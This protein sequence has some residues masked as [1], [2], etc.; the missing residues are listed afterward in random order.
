MSIQYPIAGEKIWA[1]SY[2]QSQRMSVL[3][4]AYNNIYPIAQT[5]PGD[6]SYGSSLIGYYTSGDSNQQVFAPT[7]Y[8][9]DFD[10][11]DDHRFL[12]ICQE[13]RNVQRV[14]TDS[15]DGLTWYTQDK[16]WIDDTG[17]YEILVYVNTV[18]QVTGY[19]VDACD[20][21]ITFT[22]DQTGN[23][24]TVSYYYVDPAIS[25]SKDILVDP[26]ICNSVGGA[27]PKILT[28]LNPRFDT[29]DSSTDP[30][31]WTVS[32]T[33]AQTASTFGNYA[34][35]VPRLTATMG[36]TKISQTLD[37]ATA[38]AGCVVCA[39]AKC[40]NTMKLRVSMDAGMTWNELVFTADATSVN[41]WIF[42]GVQSRVQTTTQ[43]IIEFFPQNGAT[44]TGTA[45]IE[46]IGAFEGGLS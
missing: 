34:G 38:S 20:G 17:I 45:D 21:T 42:L 19:T 18:L 15:G 46:F 8:V 10:Y 12:A 25:Y 28:I 23:D 3:G 22:S 7:T 30:S 9:T 4:F 29:W 2:I 35:L 6:V 27:T 26:V 33:C 14:M 5:H 31:K 39:V 41:K 11:G 32:G 43:P 40:T 44:T 24:V 16:N 1:E 36:I 13:V 37:L